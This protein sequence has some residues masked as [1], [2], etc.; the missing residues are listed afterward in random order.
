MR[1]LSFLLLVPYLRGEVKTL[2]ATE[3]GKREAEVKGRVH[4]VHVLVEANE[5]LLPVVFEAHEDH[6]GAQ[7][8]QTSQGHTRLGSAHKVRS[9]MGDVLVFRGWVSMDYLGA[10]VVA[11]NVVVLQ[12]SLHSLF[13]IGHVHLEGQIVMKKLVM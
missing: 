11:L 13:Q 9:L 5:V 6:V 1:Y 8:A 3:D 12:P 7:L 2:L 10:R 4:D